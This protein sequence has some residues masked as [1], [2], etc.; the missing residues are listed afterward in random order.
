LTDV[1]ANQLNGPS[2]VDHGNWIGTRSMIIEP[3]LVREMADLMIARSGEATLLISPL[4][5]SEPFGTLGLDQLREAPT[6]Q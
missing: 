5:D 3:D 2:R 6:W 4:D 1:F